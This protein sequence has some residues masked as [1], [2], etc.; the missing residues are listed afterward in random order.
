L[1]GAGFFA[2]N[3]LE[4]ALKWHVRV[5]RQVAVTVINRTCVGRHGL[6]IL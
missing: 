1:E 2:Q 6:Y 3:L 4:N 5:Y